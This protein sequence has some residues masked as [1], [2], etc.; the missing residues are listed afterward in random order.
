MLIGEVVISEKTA[1]AGDS[2]AY[3]MDA[4]MLQIGGKERSKKDF[5]KIL[6][7]AGLEI[8]KIWPAAAGHQAI[9]EAKLKST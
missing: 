9:V 8:V 7:P 5:V 1:V 2:S 6:E 3:W 4:V